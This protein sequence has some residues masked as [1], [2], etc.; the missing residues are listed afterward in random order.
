[1]R[2]FDT[3]RQDVQY[4][5]RGLRRSP[6]FTVTVVATLALGIGA[7]AAMFG[8]LDRLMLRP[9][10]Y[11]RDAGDVHRVYT[12]STYRDERT[13]GPVS[14]YTRFLD[15]SRETSSF[16]LAAGFTSRT[17]A[18]GSGSDS[19][20]RSVGVV[21]AAFFS[22]FDAPPV[23]GRYFLPS[24]DTTPVG[25][26][27]SI[28]SYEYWQN[29]LGGEEI[30]GKPLRVWNVLT[31]VVGITPPGF[32]GVFDADPPAVY[33]PIT[34]YAGNNPSLNDRNQYY[35]RYNWGWMD[36][37]VRRKAGVS[38]ASAN[39]DLTQAMVKSWDT[40]VEQE[41]GATP[42][43]LAR[44]VA[45]VGAL[46]QAAGPDPSVEART[47]WW[48]SA[49]AIVVLLIACSNVA[50]LFL[51]RALQRRRE[52]A[53]RI[54]LGGGRARLMRHWFTEALVLALLGCAAGI[55]VA[56][57][58]G[59]GIR[60]LFVGSG[61]PIAVATDWRTVGLAMLLSL[62]AALLT[63]LAPALISMQRG[64]SAAL[65]AGVREGTHQRSGLRAGLVIFQV[66]LSLVLLVG[67]GLFVRS[68]SKVRTMRLG[69][70]LDR[71]VLVSRNMRGA[72]VPD[73]VLITLQQRM[74]A[75]AQAHPD[76][77]HAAVVS[78]VPFWSTESRSLFVAGIDSVRR[79]GRFTYQTASGDYFATMGTR[80]LRGRA[81]DAR[82]RAGSALVA[83]V[84]ES[85]ARV[86]W[87]GKDAIG[88]QMKVGSDTAA[89]TTVIGIAEDAVQ[90]EFTADDQR[91]RYY[92]P[93]DQLQP[94]RGNYLIARMRSDAGTGSETLRKALQEVMPGDSYVTAR[95]LEEVVA[96]QMRSWK[97]G[98]TMFAAFGILAL[99][100]AAIGLHGVM[101]YDVAQ[102]MH[103]LG[104][105]VALGAQARDLL[106]LVVRQGM[107]LTG[108]GVALG[109][110]I[111]FAAGGQVQ[112]LLFEQEARDVRVYAVVAA[113]LLL[114]A[115]VATLVPALRASRADPNV[116]LRAD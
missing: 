114:A 80:L 79:L 1:M 99:L 64:I 16:D 92:L 44:P 29:E 52:T 27:V 60:A 116:A 57:W 76:V 31:T 115:F 105:R 89:F 17:V 67:A 3:V 22:F 108:I 70:D 37:M 33:L 78:S 107:V 50:N 95:P 18:V 28:V 91:L 30:V 85:M 75:A 53:V 73:S 56:Q 98:A 72:Q 65:K 81:F 96:T 61:A 109:V 68:F 39:A 42:R 10:P 97:F 101:G 48:V 84:S 4:A 24:E 106:Q 12:Q 34:T 69:F 6:A 15:L 35:T 113:V 40:F 103:E 112:P 45:M 102:R 88:Q 21:S 49:I 111:A 5:F 93:I 41:P 43:A 110:A 7:N 59:A 13:T 25:A 82:D 100:V 19:R 47:V 14:E 38:E 74:L 104:V 66:S 90:N 26:P 46:K 2:I 58:G 63:G 54:A 20:E 87:P 62:A 11:L 83:V 51:A 23:R 32:V 86:L 9:F 36:M 8:I 71:Q 94:Q 77:E 55:L